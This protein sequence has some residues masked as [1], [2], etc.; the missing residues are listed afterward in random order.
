M[1]IT[2]KYFATL[3]EQLGREEQEFDASSARTVADV[4]LQ[5]SGRPHWPHNLLCARNQIF[6]KPD[7]TVEEGDEIAFFPPVSGG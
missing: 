7:A 2:V 5:A 3:R 6:C 4:W 1:L